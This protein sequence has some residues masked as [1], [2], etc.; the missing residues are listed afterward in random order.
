MK[1]A[2]IGLF[3]MFA[4]QLCTSE[5]NEIDEVIGSNIDSNYIGKGDKNHIPSNS[6][7]VE[8]FQ[9]DNYET[10]ISTRTESRISHDFNSPVSNLQGEDLSAKWTGN[11]YFGSGDYVFSVKSDK[12]IKVLIDERVVL[13]DLDN[14][15]ETTYNI[16]Q[17]LDGVH[18]VEVEY[19]IENNST[20][21]NSE[22][23]TAVETPNKDTSTNSGSSTV[24]NGSSNNNTTNNTEIATETGNSS[25]DTSTNA[26]NSSDGNSSAESGNTTNTEV[27]SEPIV[28]VENN[29]PT[30]EVNWE[31]VQNTVSDTLYNKIAALLRQPGQKIYLEEAVYIESKQIVIPA[32][33]SL[34]GK[35]IGKTIIKANPSFYYTTYASS[36]K[37]DKFLIKMSGSN[38]AL[39]DLTLQGDNKKVWGGLYIANNSNVKVSSVKFDRFYFMATYIFQVNNLIFERS[40]L[41]ESSMT[42]KNWETAYM[43][44]NYLKNS[45]IRYCKFQGNNGGGMKVKFNNKKYYLEN[46]KIH[47]NEYKLNPFHAW[48][49]PDGRHTSNYALEVQPNYVGIGVVFSNNKSNIGLSIIK[50]D[51]KT[52]YDEIYIHDNEFDLSDGASNVYEL[53]GVDAVIERDYVK[54]STFIIAN[55]ARAD[56]YRMG[57]IKV[58]NCVFDFQTKGQLLLYQ[59]GT[60][61]ER[62][63]MTESTIFVSGSSGLSQLLNHRKQR[64]NTLKNVYINN[65]IFCNKS[66]KSIPITN[67][68]ITNSNISNNKF[69]GKW[70]FNGFTKNENKTKTL[71]EKGTKPMPFFKSNIQN[72]GASFQ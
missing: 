25:N 49:L 39:S 50:R 48:A 63:E 14:T 57:N 71:N 11:F 35:G 66:S 47:H 9:N 2:M 21:K 45:E 7:L 59:G 24:T 36:L 17:Q 42:G 38:S 19:N 18:K 46:V 41:I 20:E 67:A 10:S 30:I 64:N 28:E 6:F 1:K 65:N 33:K 51:G 8:Y 22:T 54:N 3:V 68:P 12:G 37:L 72:F 23:S 44:F 27:S 55:F 29:T 61:M 62:F 70:S 60:N 16:D 26:N 31:N 5:L 58:K 4:F 52:N 40:E 43:T 34:I 13:N 32:G 69:E 53:Q 15:S 56:D